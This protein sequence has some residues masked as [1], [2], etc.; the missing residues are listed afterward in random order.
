MAEERLSVLAQVK[1]AAG[2]DV[3]IAETDC[4][5]SGAL[6]IHIDEKKQLSCWTEAVARS[7]ERPGRSFLVSLS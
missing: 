5:A 1:F 6:Q 7:D 4:L 2:E 3:S